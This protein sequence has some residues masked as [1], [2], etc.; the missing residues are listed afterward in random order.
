MKTSGTYIICVLLTKKELLNSK[1]SIVTT[2][3][4]KELELCVKN[5]NFEKAAVLRDKL[6][7]LKLYSY[8]HNLKLIKVVK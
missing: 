4:E 6:N 5:E 2:E 7:K 3:I 8:L 1:I